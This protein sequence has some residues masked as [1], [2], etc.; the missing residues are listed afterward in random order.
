MLTENRRHSRLS[1][2]AGYL[3]AALPK[4]FLKSAWLLAIPLIVAG[5]ALAPAWLERNR[6]R[7]RG[8]PAVG[9]EAPDFRL[10]DID[11]KEFHLAEHIGSRPLVLEFGSAT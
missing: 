6:N 8:K 5:V 2:A 9:E 4:L 3:G 1:R 11:G 7:D 10:T